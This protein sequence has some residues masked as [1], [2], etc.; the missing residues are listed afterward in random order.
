V[1]VVDVVPEDLQLEA[2]TEPDG[3]N[4]FVDGHSVGA[5]HPG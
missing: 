3:E 5:V 4:G 2:E 1:H